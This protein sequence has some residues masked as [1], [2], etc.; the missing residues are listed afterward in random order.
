MLDSIQDRAFA[1]RLRK[2]YL[3]AAAAI[4]RLSDMDLVKYETD[5]VED[6]PDLA[7]WEEMAPVIRDTVMDVNSLLAVI[8]EQFPPT[9]QGGLADVVERAVNETGGRTRT[10]DATSAL[11]AAMHQL[12]QEVTELG[13]SMR[14]PETV[15]DRWN[16]LSEVQRFRTRFR[17]DMGNLVFQSAQVF[18]DVHPREVVPGYQEEIASAVTIRATVSDLL[19][20]IQAR[21]DKVREAESEDSQWHAQQL[22]KELD[23]F[24]KTPAYRALR[25]QDKRAI[26]ERRGKLGLLAGRANAAK[27]ELE[28]QL[29]P[30][31]EL[32]NQL[33]AVNNRQ[34]LQQHDREVLAACGV[35]LEQVQQQLGSSPEEAGRTLSEAVLSAQELYGRDPQLDAFLRRA[36]KTPIATLAGA[37][38]VESVEA[39]RSLLASIPV[40]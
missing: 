27:P 10:E 9:I 33:M 24:G 12:A 37:E 23:L 36:R 40:M 3:A 16:L 30:V 32:V 25:A 29:Q 1:A 39:F 35:K 5:T 19:R 14:K 28:A 17:Q 8:R 2:V 21:A 22:E 34:N 20:V 15:S 18:S 6:S 13:E 26:V 11:H 4:A 38:L 7:L 31:V